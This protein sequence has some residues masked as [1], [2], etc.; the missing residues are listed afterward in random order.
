MS[1]I[2]PNRPI[3]TRLIA[4]TVKPGHDAEFEAWQNRVSEQIRR[5]PG[6]LRTDILPAAMTEF[7]HK[8]IVIHRFATEALSEV[9]DILVGQG[10]QNTLVGAESTDADE[11]I[12]TSNEIIPGK[13]AEYEA[14][15][16]AATGP[17]VSS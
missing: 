10:T 15:D 9:P 12:V 13:E 2:E 8:W 11:T 16:R 7:G 1:G 3:V 17:W 4:R 6:A 5:V 14:A